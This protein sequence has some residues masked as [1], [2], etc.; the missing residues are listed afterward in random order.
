VCL[1]VASQAVSHQ[2]IFVKLT[3]NEVKMLMSLSLRYPDVLEYHELMEHL[4]LD[5]DSARKNTLETF[6]SRLRHKLVPIDRNYLTI[7]TIRNVG[8]QLSSGMTIHT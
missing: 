3:E 7:K 1:N 4:G 2:N 6:V 8:Y 5:L